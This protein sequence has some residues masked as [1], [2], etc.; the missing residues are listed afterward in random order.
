MEAFTDTLTIVCNGF[1]FPNHLEN[2]KEETL[3]KKGFGGHGF[4][5]AR[6]TV[7]YSSGLS[8]GLLNYLGH[9]NNGGGDGDSY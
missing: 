9:Q 4:G 2:I 7:A 8:V 1:K 5:V 3:W 6:K